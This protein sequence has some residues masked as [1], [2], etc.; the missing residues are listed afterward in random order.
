MDHDGHQLVGCVGDP[1][2]VE[3]EHLRRLLDGPEDGPR[4]DGRADLAEVEVERGDD[5]EV[6]AA[7]AHAPE[8]IGVLGLARDDPLAFGGD[9]LH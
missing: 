7:A 4:D 5:A 1:V 3:A 6:A 2:A 8:E 9:E